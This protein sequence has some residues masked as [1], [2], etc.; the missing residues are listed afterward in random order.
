MN[1][2]QPVKAVAAAD[3]QMLFKVGASS[4]I[5]WSTPRSLRPPLARSY[6]ASPDLGVAHHDRGPI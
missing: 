3:I 1:L 4:C 5:R 6:G 2:E